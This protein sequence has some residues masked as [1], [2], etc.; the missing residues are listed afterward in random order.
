VSKRD[1]AAKRDALLILRAKAAGEDPGALPISPLA[2][3]EAALVAPLAV[4]EARLGISRRRG[5]PAGT[6]AAVRAAIGL[7]RAEF[8]RKN[9]REPTK[10]EWAREMS[11]AKGGDD[12]QSPNQLRTLQRVLKRGDK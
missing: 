6:S 7:A 4:L 5:R 8:I 9:G 11:H 10:A 2:R 1:E 3:L 12:K